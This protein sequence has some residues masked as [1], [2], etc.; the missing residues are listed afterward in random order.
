LGV[1]L[2][3]MMSA[4]PYEYF[5]ARAYPQLQPGEQLPFRLGLLGAKKPSESGPGADEKEVQLRV[6]FSV[7]GVQAD[8]IVN[9]AG[10]RVS[11]GTADGSRWNS[12]WEH[13][14][15][16]IFPEQTATE[17][18][19]SMKRDEF[20]RMQSSPVNLRI[21]V[22]YTLFRDADKR[23]FVIPGGA[24]RLAEVGLCST[25]QVFR[26]VQ[27]LAPM[28]KPDSLLITSELS[29][30][31]CPVLE[32][33]TPA[34]PGEMARGWI[35]GDASAPAEFGISP[36]KTV[37]LY[38]TISNRVKGWGSMGLCPGTPVILSHPV[39]VAS[40]RTEMAFTAVQ[41]GSYRQAP[42]DIGTVFVHGV[43]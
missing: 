13:F 17:I 24:F 31:T 10:V 39:S 5:L 33:D 30:G 41:L 32:Q 21:E 8:A 9:L 19:F 12:G 7:S 11:M 25:Q 34:Q 40:N 35:Q 6:P 29:T 15:R 2:L 36:V 27:C 3:V 1:A 20:L 26:K 22:A 14:G 16:D 18:D 43:K 38:V 42:L 4:S 23:Q 28:R 37:E